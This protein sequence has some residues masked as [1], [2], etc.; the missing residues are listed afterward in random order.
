MLKVE[1]IQTEI[2]SLSGEEYARLRIWFSEREI[3]KNGINRLS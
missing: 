1:E 2:E 3:G